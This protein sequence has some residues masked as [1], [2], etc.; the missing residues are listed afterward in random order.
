MRPWL[1]AAVGFWDEA[2]TLK[3]YRPIQE[4]VSKV[5][6]HLLFNSLWQLIQ[7]G[8]RWLSLSHPDGV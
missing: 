6:K 3:L 7:A 2:L 5:A 4:A 1:R 8:R